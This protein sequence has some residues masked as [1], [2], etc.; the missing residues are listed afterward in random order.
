LS[1][2]GSD[3]S[4]SALVA[5]SLADATDV[6]LASR[7]AICPS[8]IVAP[9]DSGHDPTRRGITIAHADTTAADT[10]FRP[11]DAHDLKDA[12]HTPQGSN[13]PWNFGASGLTPS[14]MDPNSHNFNMFA[15]QM[16]GY[17]APTPGG[18]H[19]LYHSQAGDLHTPTFGGLGTPLSMPTSESAMQAGRQAA[20]FQGFQAHLPHSMQ[21]PS[22]QPHVNP[23]Q[24]HQHQHQH[25]QQGFPPHHFTHQPSFENLEAAIDDS[26]VDD[27]GMD[28]RMMQQQQ[29]QHHSPDMMFHPQ[30]MSNKMRPPPAHPL[31]EKYVHPIEPAKCS[32]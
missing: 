28:V 20:A 16:P 27:V 10:T 24:M 31:G 14:L 21:H 5:T 15:S 32:C 25:Q 1:Q 17:Y 3:S 23:F 12:D 26:P 9:S 13:E 22:F 30:S 6:P 8:P 2:P 7:Y 18:T 4:A 29:Q 11:L 19:T